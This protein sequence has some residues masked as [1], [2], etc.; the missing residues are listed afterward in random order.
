MDNIQWYAVYTKSRNEKQVARE[1]EEKGV[2]HFLPLVK[3]LRQWSDR[4]KFVYVPLFNSYL[5]VK[6]DIKYRVYVL[7]IP[8]VVC[9]VNFKQ[10]FPPIPEWQ[11][12]NLKIILGSAEK[13]EISRDN[14]QLGEHVTV[15]GGSFK[16]LHGTLV[17]YRGKQK[18]LVRIDTINQNLLLEINPVYIEK[19]N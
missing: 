4:R 19:R 14:F 9:F 18:F 3:T 13:F 11:I 2:E 5:F 7:E 17:E 16:G 10:E 1:L 8:G 6:I 15:N 12:N